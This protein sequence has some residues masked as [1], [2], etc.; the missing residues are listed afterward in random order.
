VLHAQHDARG[1]WCREL[2]IRISRISHISRISRIKPVFQRDLDASRGLPIQSATPSKAQDGGHGG[3]AERGRDHGQHG[4]VPSAARGGE[5]VLSPCP[6]FYVE[7]VQPAPSSSGLLCAE[8][9]RVFSARLQCPLTCP[10]CTRRDPIL[11]FRA[12]AAPCRSCQLPHGTERIEWLSGRVVRLAKLRGNQRA[13]RD[14]VGR[15]ERTSHPRASCRQPPTL[16]H[17][18]ACRHRASGSRQ[19]AHEARGNDFP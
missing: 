10:M 7:A 4:G 1:R 6:T 15:C 19:R 8:P 18:H 17:I 16:S 5:S 3:G 14:R 13:W 9:P 12:T 2:G 11:R